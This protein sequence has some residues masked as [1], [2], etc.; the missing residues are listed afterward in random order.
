MGDE[1]EVNDKPRGLR[2][3]KRALNNI[4]CIIMFARGQ[5]VGV[6]KRIKLDRRRGGGCLLG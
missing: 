2:R 3:F 5:G 4:G 1:E 6:R